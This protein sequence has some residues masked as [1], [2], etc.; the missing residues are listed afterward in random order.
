ML[1]QVLERAGIAMPAGIN[2]ELPQAPR[3]NLDW[4]RFQSNIPYGKLPLQDAIDFS[5]YLVNLQSGK[6][7]FASGVA[8]VGGRTHIGLITKREG[9]RMLDEPE[10]HHTN[11]GFV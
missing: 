5:A 6:S 11:V 1:Q 7:K 2:T 3:F 9:F 8:T 4:D 10:L